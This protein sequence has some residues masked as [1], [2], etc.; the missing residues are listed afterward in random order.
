MQGTWH[1]KPGTRVKGVGRG[2]NL[3]LLTER[4]REI[5]KHKFN[6]HIPLI[7]NAYPNTFRSI[8][9]GYVFLTPFQGIEKR[10]GG[11]RQKDFSNVVRGFSS[12]H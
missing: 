1:E 3:E 7:L 4:M 10:G 8:T 12:V 5:L 6:A 2:R 11:V 9:F